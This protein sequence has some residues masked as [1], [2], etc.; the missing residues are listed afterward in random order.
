MMSQSRDSYP[1]VRVP[2]NRSSIPG[3]GD[4]T[5]WDS[6]GI[7]AVVVALALG[8]I[9]DGATLLLLAWVTR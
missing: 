5:D 6:H 3:V 2:E 9:T 8:L 4:K 7:Y 1:P